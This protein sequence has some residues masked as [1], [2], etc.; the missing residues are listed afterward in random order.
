MDVFGK[1][2]TL[3]VKGQGHTSHLK[4]AKILKNIQSYFRNQSFALL[5]SLSYKKK[6]VKKY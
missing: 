1:I 5:V 3:G 4:I 2:L 6:F